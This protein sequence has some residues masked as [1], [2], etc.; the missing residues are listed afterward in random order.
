MEVTELA[1][2]LWRWTGYHE[3]WKQDVGCV[4]LEMPDAIVLIDPQI[5]SEDEARFLAA[6]DR[7]VKR[8]RKPVHV[9]ITIFWHARSAGALAPRY[10]ARIWAPSRGRAAVQRRTEAVT[11]VFRPGDVLPGGIRAYASGRSTEHVLWI[12]SHRA[13]VPGDSIL[14]DD[15]GGVRLCPE[16]W[17]PQSVRHPKMR[18]AL[19]PLLELPIERILVSHGEPV[20]EGGR[21][22]LARALQAPSAA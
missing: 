13:L 16:S 1:P 22:A 7:D 12:P 10:E 4:Y 21:A 8:E 11:D 20:L 6:L 19:Q 3:E 9:V 17:L 18:K 2:G 14:G 5:P 15:E